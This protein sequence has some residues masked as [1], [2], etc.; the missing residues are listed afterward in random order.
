MFQIRLQIIRIKLVE[1]TDLLNGVKTHNFCSD[2][3]S[4]L[5]IVMTT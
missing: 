2:F 3:K 5:S 1:I 4:V